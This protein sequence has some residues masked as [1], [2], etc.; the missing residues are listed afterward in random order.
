MSSHHIVREKQEPALFIRRLGNFDEE[1]L[2]QL[3]EWSPTLIT[4]AA[5]YEKM[6]SLGLKVDAVVINEAAI[7][8]GTA[9]TLQENTQLIHTQTAELDAVLEYLE[10]TG[11]K[12]VNIID[13][14]NNYL[15]TLGAHIDHLNIV[16]YTTEEKA[17]AI[18]SGFSIWKSKGSLFRIEVLTY[19]E[20]SNLVQEE[21]G[22][23]LVVNDG[24]V[25]FIFDVSYLFIREVL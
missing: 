15:R 23:F 2:G 8:G 18:P 13:T 4:G 22:D 11:Y 12:A 9:S 17:Y 25:T 3:L 20:T 16:V 10:K 21:N 6:L 14:E 19:F 24:F 7:S 5:E 1:Y